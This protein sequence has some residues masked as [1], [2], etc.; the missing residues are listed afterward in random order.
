MYIKLIK[1]A[2]FISKTTKEEKAKKNTLKTEFRLKGCPTAKKKGLKL[3][4][5]Q[6]IYHK[7]VIERNILD[8]RTQYKKSIKCLI[9]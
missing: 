3:A 7:L 1:E 2:I 8:Y 4:I 6:Y 9:S 5:I